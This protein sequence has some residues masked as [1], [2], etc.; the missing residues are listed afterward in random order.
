M[1]QRSRLLI[2]ERKEVLLL[3]VLAV[4]VAVF[5]FTFGIH[6]GK[7]VPPRGKA[8]SSTGSEVGSVKQI[9]DQA[10]TRAEAQE[11]VAAASDVVDE[12]LDEALRQEVAETGL[13]L[14]QPV[15][16][17]LP[18]TTVAEKKAERKA[19]RKAE[20]KPE[21]K[22]VSEAKVPSSV[23]YALQILAVPASDAGAL[24]AEVQKL[25]KAGL[26]PWV[27]KADL[28]SKGIW[29]RVYH[30]RF[31]TREEAETVGARLKGEG[32]ISGFVTAKAPAGA[33]QADGGAAPAVDTHGK[34]HHE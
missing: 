24:E 23:P 7:R 28:G 1:N 6:L 3:G 8:G 21:K 10:P 34:D 16:V 17:E 20:K 2:Y 11:K 19:E 4:L 14:D 18:R 31:A 33:P 27:R 15:Q 26:Q 5:A 32:K 29:Y 25:E 12:A 13:K 22:V 30:G 9:A